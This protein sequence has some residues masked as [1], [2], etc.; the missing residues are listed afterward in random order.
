MAI[1][2]IVTAKEAA[3]FLGMGAVRLRLLI[4]EGRIKAKKHGM[5]WLVDYASLKRFR[6]RP[7]G[8]PGHFKKKKGDKK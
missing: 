4:R 1:P 6:P 8:S 5:V 3:L 7:S 2:G